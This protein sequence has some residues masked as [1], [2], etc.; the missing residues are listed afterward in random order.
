MIYFIFSVHEPNQ[1]T[2][3]PDTQPNQHLSMTRPR[4]NNIEL[5]PCPSPLLVDMT[6]RWLWMLVVTEIVME[7]IDQRNDSW[8]CLPFIYQ[9]VI[10]NDPMAIIIN[11]ETQH[12][13]RQ[14]KSQLKPRTVASGWDGMRWWGSEF[15]SITFVFL[16]CCWIE[17]FSCYC[18]C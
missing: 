8:P 2:S 9:R 15:Y 14:N 5:S 16:Y 13:V 1:Q 17:L 7:Y 11:I 10:I 3:Q 6:W 4:T 18:R 12:E